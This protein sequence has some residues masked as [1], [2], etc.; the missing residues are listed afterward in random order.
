MSVYGDDFQL[1]RQPGSEKIGK[2]G[3]KKVLVLIHASQNNTSIL[4]QIMLN[5]CNAH[6][7]PST[8]PIQWTQLNSSCVSTLTS[9][10][11]GHVIQIDLNTFRK[12]VDANILH[13]NKDYDQYLCCFNRYC[14]ASEC[15]NNVNSY[16]S[17]KNGVEWEEVECQNCCSVNQFKVI[18]AT[19]TIFTYFNPRSLANV[20]GEIQQIESLCYA[21]QKLSVSCPN[22][23]YMFKADQTMKPEPYKDT[24]QIK[25]QFSP[26]ARSKCLHQPSFIKCTKS[27]NYWQ[28]WCS[29]CR[30]FY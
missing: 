10:S 5:Q 22:D 3:S 18:N 28:F 26:F 11:K 30:K 20:T 13:L 7:L 6:S 14:T 29:H 17:I 16:R 25:L 1:W 12:N 21:V 8:S 24:L 2:P 27:S 23:R 4:K 9:K 19:K 15:S